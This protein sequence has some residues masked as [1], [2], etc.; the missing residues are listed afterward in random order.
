MLT[1][2]CCQPEKANRPYTMTNP[3]EHTN[4]T[5]NYLAMW[6]VYQ[7]P[8]DYPHSF[9][10]RKFLIGGGT[11][12]TATDEVLVSESL[13]LIRRQ[14]VRWGLYRIERMPGDEPQI[15]EVWL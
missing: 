9:V 1:V 3:Q 15:V 2:Y 12:A 8:L 5:D 10:A 13:F 4:N 11:G 14:M 6:T 7:F